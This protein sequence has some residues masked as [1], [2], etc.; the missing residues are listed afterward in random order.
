MATILWRGDAAAVAQVNTITPANVNI[1]N[2]FSVTINGKPIAYTAQAATVADVCNGLLA[3]LTASSLSEFGEVNWTADATKITVTARAPGVP[4][5]QTS[6]ASGGTAT[7]VT[8]TT[9]AS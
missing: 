7:L 4:F 9:V 3:L 1:G 5:T 6:S 8:A 2:V